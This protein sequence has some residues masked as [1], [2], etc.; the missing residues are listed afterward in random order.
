MTIRKD[1]RQF[2][3]SITLA[4]LCL[5]STPARLF[6]LAEKEAAAGWLRKIKA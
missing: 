1:N 3:A 6:Y 5:I 4:A 2:M